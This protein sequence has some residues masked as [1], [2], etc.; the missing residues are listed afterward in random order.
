MGESGSFPSPSGDFVFLHYLPIH[1][2]LLVSQDCLRRGGF[3]QGNASSHY[4]KK[5]P[6]KPL[7]TR[8]G[9]DLQIPD[10]LPLPFPVQF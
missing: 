10:N 3:F 5:T 4:P 8:N 2:L 1:L 7:F 6:L 9:G